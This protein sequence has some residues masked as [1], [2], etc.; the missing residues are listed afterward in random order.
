MTA[1]ALV[2]QHS[3]S[4]NV[5]LLGGWLSGGGLELKICRPYAGDDVPDTVQ[6]YDALVVMGG[7]MAAYDD[8]HGNPSAP[9]IPAVKKLL[10]TAVDDG[11]PVLG[12]CLGGQLLAEA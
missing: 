12:V 9:W 2:V 6:P 8:E 5:G 7:E 10:R 1:T 3:D 4:E 11:I